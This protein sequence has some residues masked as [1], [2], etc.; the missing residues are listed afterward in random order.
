MSQYVYSSIFDAI[1]SGVFL[2]IILQ[3]LN[4]YKDESRAKVIVMNTLGVIRSAVIYGV[5]AYY[6]DRLISRWW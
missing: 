2:G 6:L 4:P 1:R 5:S 3:Y